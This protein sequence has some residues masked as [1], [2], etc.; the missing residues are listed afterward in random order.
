MANPYSCPGIPALGRCFGRNPVSGVDSE[1][2]TGLGA[3]A[4]GSSIDS[5][6]ISKEVLN[7]VTRFFFVIGN[8]NFYYFLLLVKVSVKHLLFVCCDRSVSVIGCTYWRVNAY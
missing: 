2:I 6:F 1:F 4:R 5:V 8:S 7:T 3:L